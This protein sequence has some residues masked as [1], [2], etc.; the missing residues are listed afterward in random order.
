MQIIPKFCQLPLRINE[1]TPF[2]V[3]IH[4]LSEEVAEPTQRPIQRWRDTR[5]HPSPQLRSA[6]ASLQ[7]FSQ[8]YV[9]MRSVSVEV[10]SKSI[11]TDNVYYRSP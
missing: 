7:I 6:V 10:T 9:Y 1:S 2:R 8:I 5:L 11:M 4:L 3:K